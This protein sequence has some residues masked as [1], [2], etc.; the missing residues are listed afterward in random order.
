MYSWKIVAAAGAVITACCAVA[1]TP[2]AAGGGSYASA[3]PFYK[4]KTTPGGPG[5]NATAMLTREIFA[6]ERASSF[7]GN[8]EVPGR[9]LPTNDWWTDI[10]NNRFSGALWSYPAM[11]KTSDEGV[12]I[13][14]PSYWAD[15][16]KE[17]KSRTNITV[18]AARYRAD[19]AI[20]A[21]WHDWD[22][23][24]RLPAKSGGGE[25]KVTA[26]HGSPFTW[27]E[28]TGGV[29]A[30]IK[31]G[32]AARLFG[33]TASYTGV[34]I[35]GDLYGVYFPEGS[36]PMLGGGNS[37]SARRRS[38]FRWRFCARRPT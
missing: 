17:I 11:L 20:A 27:I 35:D 7:D 23:T 9:A 1:Q 34:N 31:T 13:N 30:E 12:Q 21:D 29:K 3:P 32:A 37:L 18:G 15:A 28:Y 33:A 8:V 36:L 26:V 22:V 4:A 2:V 38:G 19:A 14:W 5:F 16:G 6:D 24:F 10:I 25:M